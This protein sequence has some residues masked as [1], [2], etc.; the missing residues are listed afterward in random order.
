[1][2]R[3]EFNEG[4]PTGSGLIKSSPAMKTK[5]PFDK[6]FPQDR[7]IESTVF[8]NRDERIS[9]DIGVGEKA[10]SLPVGHS[11]IVIDPNPMHSATRGI[12]L[13]DKPVQIEMFQFLHLLFR[14]PVEEIGMV[15]LRLDRDEAGGFR[16]SDETHGLAGNAKT[17]FEFWAHRNPF[18]ELTEGIREE[19]VAFMSPVKP[20]FIAEE[21]TTDADAKGFR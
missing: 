17:C 5:D 11:G 19:A 20:D 6:V 3:M 21:A 14:I 16:G 10:S 15:F 2:L 1:M 18:N 7:I 4:S 13:K 8:L 12:L 9:L